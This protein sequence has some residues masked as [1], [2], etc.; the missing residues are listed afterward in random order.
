MQRDGTYKIVS[1]AN[2]EFNAPESV[3]GMTPNIVEAI[4]MSLTELISQGAG[5]PGH[6]FNGTYLEL[7]KIIDACGPDYF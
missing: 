5:S 7:R 3:N 2:I 6:E 4:N 1:N